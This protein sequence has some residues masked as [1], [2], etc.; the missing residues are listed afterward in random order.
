[1]RSAAP[2]WRSS[3]ADGLPLSAE[4]V[5][6]ERVPD[7]AGGLF[8]QLGE[9]PDIPGLQDL[10]PL[11]PAVVGQL[12]TSMTRQTSATD[13]PAEM[14]G[15]GALSFAEAL[16]QMLADDLLRGVANSFHG[17]V[18]GA[19]RTDVDSHSP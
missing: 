19:V 8:C 10:A 9:L 2:R 7:Q 12:V 1:M 11:P 4:D 5:A 18:P 14:A 16:G 17:G 3:C 15:S 13:L 6:P